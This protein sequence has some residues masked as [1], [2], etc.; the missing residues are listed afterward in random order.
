MLYVGQHLR[1]MAHYI[2]AVLLVVVVLV[3]ATGCGGTEERQLLGTWK[4]VQ[5]SGTMPTRISIMELKEGGIG[6]F[7]SFLEDD[8]PHPDGPIGTIYWDII[9]DKFSIVTMGP[10]LTLVQTT[11][12]YFSISDDG[13]TLVIYEFTITGGFEA[14][15]TRV[16]VE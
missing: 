15:F 12:S 13:S 14:V 10:E 3:A 16:D 8:G 7:T 4:R 11:L 5:D 2:I 9:D 1:K 6:T